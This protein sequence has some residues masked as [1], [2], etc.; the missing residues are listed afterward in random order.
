M[1]DFIIFVAKVITLCGIV[2]I[3]LKKTSDNQLVEQME[4][5]LGA[6]HHRGPNYQSFVNIN[7]HLSVGHAR[8]SII[9]LSSAAHQPMKAENGRYTLV[10]NGEI[11]N[12]QSIKSQLEN[13]GVH[14]HTHSDT[15]VLLKLLIHEG[16]KGIQQLNGFFAFAFHDALTD[17]LILARDRFG[18]KPLYFYQDAKQFIFSSELNAF[19]SFNI[20]KSLDPDALN[21]LFTFT[22]IPAPYT[23]L[24]QAKKA[25]P[26]HYYVY[27]NKVLTAKKYYEPSSGKPLKLSFEQAKNELKSKLKQ[28]VERRL[29]AD[30]PLG[31]FLSG[32]VDSSVIATV[33][34]SL[35]PDLQTYSIGFDEAFFDE[36]KY[37]KMVADKIGSQHHNLTLTQN[38]FNTHFKSFLNSLDEPFGDS[39][40]FAVYLLSQK[41]KENV[42]VALSGDGADEIFGGYRKHQA[43]WMI[44][45]S[46]GI[47]KAAVKMGATVLSPFGQNRSS[48]WGDISRKVQKLAKGYQM[49]VVERYWNWARFISESDKNQLFVKRMANFTSNSTFKNETLNDFLIQD[50]KFVLPNDMLTKVDVMSMANALEVRTPFLDH[51][52]V[53]FIN[54]LP[55]DFK[56]NKNGRKQ[57]LI[58]AFKDDLPTEVYQ[59]TKKGFEIPLL[60]WLGN[61][62]E[63]LLNSDIFSESYIENQHLFN[64]DSIQQLKKEWNHPQFGDRI[65]ILWTL[66][67]FQH[68]YKRFYTT[69]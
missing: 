19:F 35:K 54:R 59:R 23:I 25:L 34:K 7:E 8:L 10:F 49:N 27:K 50:Q 2:G 39:S 53:D 63:E 43:E 1:S 11:Y 37:A 41:T 3:S 69:T 20:D 18:I 64:F 14:F 6:I 55:A 56:V 47:K 21:A 31:S 62:L 9:D 68:W 28:A 42:T 33:A 17:I 57:L 45:E 58:E 52:L 22:Y 29:V 12:F 65:Y 30:V 61:Q 66:V 46:G 44:R 24:K 26:G 32:G 5:V 51:E 36:S 60:K 13:Q 38:D 40:A 4:S 67:V 15:E 16:T 48:K